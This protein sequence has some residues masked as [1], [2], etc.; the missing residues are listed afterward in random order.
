MAIQFGTMWKMRGEKLLPEVS[1]HK[2]GNRKILI[3]VRDF[4]VGI[5]GAFW[6]SCFT[7]LTIYI[8]TGFVQVTSIHIFTIRL[9]KIKSISWYLKLNID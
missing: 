2:I 5:F 8:C 1:S 3:V 7:K 9:F 4:P 6:C